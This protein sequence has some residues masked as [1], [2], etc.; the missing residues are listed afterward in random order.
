MNFMIRKGPLAAILTVLITLLVAS[1]GAAQTSLTFFITDVDA[2]AFPDVTFRMRAL[3]IESRAVEGLNAENI[4]VYENG[5]QVTGPQVTPHDDGPV[6][7]IFVIDMGGHSVA[8]Y[9]SA[10]RDGGVQQILSSLV[11]GGYF[12]DGTDTVMVL[13]RENQSGVDRTTTLLAPTNESTEYT[14]RVAGLSIPR[15]AGATMSLEAV[16]DALN[17]IPNLLQVPGSQTTAVI[18]LSRYVQDPAPS[19]AP[20][21]AENSAEIAMSVFTP[22]YAFQLDPFQNRKEPLLVLTEG[23]DGVYAH[24]VRNAFAS[25]VASV[26]QSIAA[27]REYYDVTYRS[28]LAN[29]DSREITVNSPTRPAEGAV[30]TYQIELSP[31]AISI[32][33]PVSNTT[34]LREEVI[35]EE[36]AVPTYNLIDVRV[37]AE[38]SWPDGHPRSI[39]SA[40]LVVN[41]IV[42]DTVEA[43]PDQTEFEFNWDLSLFNTEGIEPATLSVRLVDELGIEAETD[44]SVAVE[45]VPLEEEPGTFSMRTLATIGLPALCLILLGL[46][47][48]IGGT[49][50]L[51]RKG[52]DGAGE[53]REGKATVQP[54]MFSAEGHD[55]V[56]ATL[57]ILEGPSGM[58]GEILRIAS[59]TTSLGRDPA[60]T[61]I[62][63]YADQQSSVSRVHCEIVLE[64]DNAFRLIDKNSS[65]GT[66][67]NGRKI[68]PDVPVVIEDEDEIIMG[69][70][71]Q[72][73][74]KLEFNFATQDENRPYSG[75]ADDRTHLLPDSDP[76]DWSSPD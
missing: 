59:L 71:A 50:Y 31:P 76:G 74:V 23:S 1:S 34:L 52:S 43:T 10:F 7:Y 42:Q 14:T 70:L 19:V 5:E 66:W 67:L 73:G 51:I 75:T 33:E 17:E 28:A 22:V 11:S 57:T 56:L 30:G 32:T 3:D 47:V 48:V 21:S 60:Q 62:S 13:A 27:Q 18:F 45:V 38:V 9:N 6:T 16:N 65:A 35:T 2:S 69:D 29:P 24:L 12:V 15:T 46:A 68:H 53:G 25:T 36:G 26:Y 20:S 64:D 61:D 72:R 44:Q 49:V 37:L 8:T 58:V 63:F 54:T 55:L 40:E 39:D 41:E 4:T